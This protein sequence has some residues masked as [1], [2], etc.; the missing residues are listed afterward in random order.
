VIFGIAAMILL[1][2][3]FFLLC[4]GI[5]NPYASATAMWDQPTDIT[6]EILKTSPVQYAPTNMMADAS[7]V[8]FKPP[9]WNIKNQATCVPRWEQ[10]E[11]TNGGDKELIIEAVSSDHGMF[12]PS[13][14][15]PE[16]LQKGEVAKMQILFLAQSVGSYEG[17]VFVQ[18]NLGSVVFPVKATAV[19]NPYKVEAI[20]GAKVV[21]G[22][23]YSP[24]VSIYNP[25]DTNLHVREVFTTE[26]FLHL[27]LPDKNGGGHMLESGGQSIGRETSEAAAVEAS[28]GSAGVWTVLPKQQKTVIH[29]SF[30]SHVTGKFQGFV[31]LRTDVED[32]LVPVEITVTK[33]GVHV[34]PEVVDFQTLVSPAQSK[35]MWL[36]LSNL[37]PQPIELLSLYDPKQDRNL[38]IT[39]F[40]PKGVQVAPGGNVRFAKVTY[41]GGE[42]GHMQGKLQLII[43]D[44]DSV[45]A[46][47]DPL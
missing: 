24:P 26:G 13:L 22:E 38:H 40:D 33:G 45:S 16:T 44:T 9:S 4:S 18:T 14:S 29:V 32:L 39:G 36:T 2:S 21:V 30:I 15:Q 6:T 43:H 8:K 19:E 20:I 37:N 1:Y 28:D 34:M 31:R 10:V 5:C 23:R 27:A 47:L 42:E 3:V 41:S 7:I 25:L 35:S 12:H 17:L 46:T 11:I